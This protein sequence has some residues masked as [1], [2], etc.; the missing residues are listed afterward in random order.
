[1]ML[2]FP[3]FSPTPIHAPAG[4]TMVA[5][6]FMGVAFG[7]SDGS[8]LPGFGTLSASALSGF[9]T[10]SLLWSDGGSG[11]M[12]SANFGGGDATAALTG[13]SIYVGATAYP[14]VVINY[15]G[16]GN[17]YIETGIVANPFTSG[18]SYNI[19]IE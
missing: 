4:V 18:I 10:I 9:T 17:T 7:Y 14:I 5:G 11:G 16:G 12:I 19:R 13:K 15:D 8:S 2:V 1:M 6:E 3:T